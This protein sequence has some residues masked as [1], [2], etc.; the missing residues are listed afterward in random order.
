MSTCSSTRDEYIG[1]SSI[2]NYS[3]LLTSLGSWL[4]K[5]HYTTGTEWVQTEKHWSV[6]GSD[7]TDSLKLRYGFSTPWW[8][9]TTRRY[10]N[11]RKDTWKNFDRRNTVKF[12]GYNENLFHSWRGIL[13]FI[14]TD[15][16]KTFYSYVR[17]KSPTIGTDYKSSGDQVW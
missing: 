10:N 17:D 4:P 12:V 13:S 9:L 6:K 7:V 3:T 15:E 1:T 5:G 2:T 11:G 14:R 16:R 8:D